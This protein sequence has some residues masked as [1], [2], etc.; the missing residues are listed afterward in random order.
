MRQYYKLSYDRCT[1]TCRALCHTD[2]AHSPGYLL[3]WLYIDRHPEPVVRPNRQVLPA[4][5]QCALT[6]IHRAFLHLKQAFLSLFHYFSAYAYSTSTIHPI[7][8]QNKHDL[9]KLHYND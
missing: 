9:I 3:G 5:R 8:W 7:K 1:R 2:G 6:R 4:Q